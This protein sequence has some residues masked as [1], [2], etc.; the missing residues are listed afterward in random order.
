[1]LQSTEK[2][3]CHYASAS[4]HVVHKQN[5]QNTL[6]CDTCRQNTHKALKL[7]IY[8]YVYV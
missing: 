5:K 7:Y 6:V 3:E 2:V 8:I 4:T 1:M